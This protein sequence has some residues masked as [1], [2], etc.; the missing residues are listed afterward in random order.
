MCQHGQQILP[1]RQFLECA[2]N[3]MSTSSHIV[4]DHQKQQIASRQI[5]AQHKRL[6]VSPRH[7][8]LHRLLVPVTDSIALSTLLLPRSSAFV[9]IFL[10]FSSCWILALMSIRKFLLSFAEQTLTLSG[11][12]CI[13][14]SEWSL[15]FHFNYSKCKKSAQTQRVLE[16]KTN[17]CC[18][19]SIPSSLSRISFLSRTSLLELS[20][21]WA[22][23]S[24]RKTL[25]QKQTPLLPFI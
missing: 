24:S 14:Q 21:V 17:F 5:M 15:Q 25:K 2:A 22:D 12:I 20:F 13:L 3:V 11:K 8:R 23:C 7:L 19:S 1:S 6:R 4:N 9:Y 18:F 10:A 16:K